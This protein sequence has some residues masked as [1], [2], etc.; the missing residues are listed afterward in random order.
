MTQ[1]ARQK[2][3][4][5]TLPNHVA[6]TPEQQQATLRVCFGQGDALYH[7]L[8]A[9]VVGKAN[10]NYVLTRPGGKPIKDFRKTWRN[11]TKA[12]GI[13]PRAGKTRKPL[14][15]VWFH[16]T[17]NTAATRMIEAGLSETEAME[18]GGWKTA[19][20]FLHCHITN[21]K[22]RQEATCRMSARAKR[23]SPSRL[24]S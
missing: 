10:E 12:A 4:H 9:C 21:D 14:A 2:C 17:R 20:I 3:G 8:S 19:S 7:L 23:V 18:R 5:A 15:G 1:A 16:D 22:A 6:G 24:P 11:I 13:P